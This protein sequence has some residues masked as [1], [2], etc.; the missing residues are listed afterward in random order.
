MRLPIWCVTRQV[1]LE[2]ANRVAEL[3]NTDRSILGAS[4]GI[5]N[6]PLTVRS[7]LLN[8]ASMV[9]RTSF[10]GGGSI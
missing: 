4:E 8:P 9:D 6:K 10:E 7:D 3:R 2:A 1:R 5:S